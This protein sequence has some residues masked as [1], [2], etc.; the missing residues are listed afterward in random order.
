MDSQPILQCFIKMTHSKSNQSRASVTSVDC[1]YLYTQQ[2]GLSLDSLGS[3]CTEGPALINKKGDLTVFRTCLPWILPC[4]PQAPNRSN[5]AWNKFLGCHK[6]VL[7]H[8]RKVTAQSAVASL[9]FCQLLGLLP[10]FLIR[11]LSMW[12]TIVNRRVDVVPGHPLTA[13]RGSMPSHTLDHLLFSIWRSEHEERNTRPWA[14]GSPCF[15][16]PHDYRRH[17]FDACPNLSTFTTGNTDKPLATRLDAL[18]LIQWDTPQC[19]FI[20]VTVDI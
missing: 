9:S 6:S 4:Q 8:A 2:R 19:L 12:E 17:G 3:T 10:W 13:C 7:N 14:K 1:L 16:L 18:G 15:S 5:W 20:T 11:Q